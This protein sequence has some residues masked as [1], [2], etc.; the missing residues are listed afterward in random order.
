MDQLNE[1]ARKMFN[2]DF[3]QLSPFGQ[4]EVR[5]QHQANKGI[6][7]YEKD[8]IIQAQAAKIAELEKN[9]KDLW[10]ENED[11]QLELQRIEDDEH[12]PARSTRTRQE[13]ASARYPDEVPPLSD[14]GGYG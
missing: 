3:N 8:K 2:L 11:L 6:Q 12:S 9:N 10:D 5:L 4:H 14:S 13:Q 7:E 1:I